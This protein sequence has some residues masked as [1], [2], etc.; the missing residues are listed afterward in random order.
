MMSFPLPRIPRDRKQRRI[1]PERNG[2]LALI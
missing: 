1:T 2:E